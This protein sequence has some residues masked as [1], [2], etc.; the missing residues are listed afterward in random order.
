MAPFDLCGRGY[1][2]GDEAMSPAILTIITITRDD[3]AG[4]RATLVSTT[5]LRA[6]ARVKQVVVDGDGMAKAEAVAA[7]CRWMH[8]S[9]SG[10]AG[11]FNEGLAAVQSEWVWFLNG[12]DRVH[13][14]LDPQWLLAL[15]QT[16]QAD[17]V[18][19]AIQD[20]GADAL[21]YAPPL[22]QQW[23][24]TVCWLQQPSTI[25]RRALL[26]RA[27]GFDPHLRVCMDYDLWLRLLK[28][29]PQV[30]VVSVPFARFNT[31]GVSR[32]PETRRLL[33]RENAKVLWRHRCLFLRDVPRAGW[34][35]AKALGS[36]LKGGYF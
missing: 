5:A 28:P 21:R 26:V 24:P 12:G 2:E 36:A 27:G 1:A 17:L 8:Q 13:E 3:L 34:R 23:P 4:L 20:D 16:T 33:M 6:D 22:Q 11:A 15:L 18:T 29:K 14:T 9:G 25:V 30:D 31:G 7:G 35:Y 19:G 10:I 32:R